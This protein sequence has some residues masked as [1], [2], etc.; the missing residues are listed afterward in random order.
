MDRL[1]SLRALWTRPLTAWGS[2]RQKG[3]KACPAPVSTRL[4]PYVGWVEQHST[5]MRHSD[6]TAL[7]RIKVPGFGSG[8]DTS[9][10]AAAR[11]PAAAGPP[12]L[13]GLG[14]WV[15]IMVLSVLA[16]GVDSL[17]FGRPGTLFGLLFLAACVAGGLLVRPADLTAAP[18]SGPIA[19]TVALLLTGDSGGDGLSGQVMGLL[20]GLA[21]LTGWLYAGTL[22]AAAIV[23]V[24]W[25]AAVRRSRQR[26]R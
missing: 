19:F 22:S 6:G 14:T 11:A 15:M 26:R 5:R 2:G 12:R 18:V 21:T 13:T 3:E 10:D 25:V 23:A 17:L 20:T 7:P 1:P 16:G 24:R 9:E 4:R 8:A